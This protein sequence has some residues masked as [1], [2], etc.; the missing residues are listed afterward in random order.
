LNEEASIFSQ[1]I[2]SDSHLALF[3]TN[4]AIKLTKKKNAN[5]KRQLI[6]FKEGDKDRD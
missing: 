1:G 5:C 4:N 3:L 6:I 2:N